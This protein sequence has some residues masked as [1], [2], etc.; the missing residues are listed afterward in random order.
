LIG[1]VF[2]S[3]HNIIGK[4]PAQLRAELDSFQSVR[5][6][7]G[8]PPLLIATD[9][10]GGSVSRL[11]PLAPHQPPMASLVDATDAE[12]RATDYGSRQGHALAELGINVNFSPVVDLRPSRPPDPSDHHT[13]IA[14]RAIAAV[15]TRSNSTGRS[16]TIRRDCACWKPMFKGNTNWA[17]RQRRPPDAFHIQSTHTP[18]ESPTQ[19]S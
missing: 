12:Q 1:G 4:T 15:P 17:S 6:R 11:S 18:H 8:L 9:Q 10:E 16:P 19:V 7:A 14:D 2:V 3:H 5:R 13:R